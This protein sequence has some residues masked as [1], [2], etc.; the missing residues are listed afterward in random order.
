MNK[1]RIQFLSSVEVTFKQVHG[2]HSVSV[3][4]CIEIQG[5]RHVLL[6]LVLFKGKQLNEVAFFKESLG[7]RTCCKNRSSDTIEV[8]TDKRIWLREG[9]GIDKGLWCG[10]RTFRIEYGKMYNLRVAKGYCYYKYK[11]IYEYKGKKY[12]AQRTD[13]IQ[14]K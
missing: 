8:V 2:A 14:C 12:T 6:L 11:V 5:I 7:K 4:K 9:N 1:V 10:T 13:W 3:V